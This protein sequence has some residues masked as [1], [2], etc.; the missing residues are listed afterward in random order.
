MTGLRLDQCGDLLTIAEYSAWAR[1]SVKSTYN[2]LNRGG[3][4]VPP[5]TIKPR[6]MWRRAALE[7]KLNDGTVLVRQRSDLARR[8][9][10]A[11][12]A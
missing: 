5:F 1:Q 3:L 4:L 11:V 8:R 9:L 7:A 6:P 12:P 10:R 2:Q